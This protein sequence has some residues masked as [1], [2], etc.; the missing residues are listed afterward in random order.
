[1]TTTCSKTL[2]PSSERDDLEPAPETRRVGCCEEYEVA[3]LAAY[4]V[5]GLVKTAAVEANHA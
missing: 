3:V 5:F 1:M 4:R 2:P